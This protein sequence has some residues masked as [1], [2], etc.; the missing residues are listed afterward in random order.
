MDSA[1]QNILKE[2]RLPNGFNLERVTNQRMTELLKKAPAIIKWPFFEEL[3]SETPRMNVGA[4]TCLMAYEIGKDQ[5][6]S[7]HF[8]VVAESKGA[9][10]KEQNEYQ[11]YKSWLSHVQSFLAA[12]DES[13]LVLLGQHKSNLQSQTGSAIL[14][15]M[16]QKNRAHVN[17]DLKKA[18][19]DPSRIIDLRGPK[20]GSTAALYDPKEK[21]LSYTTYPPR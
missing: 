16:W 15:E 6:F 8:T 13:V 1:P 3:S 9:D 12:D 2:S 11:T 4:S 21:R 17:E 7:G 14:E 10:A 5:S 19:I 20:I 18:G